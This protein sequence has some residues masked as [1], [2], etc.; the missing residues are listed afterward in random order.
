MKKYRY[1]FSNFSFWIVLIIQ[2][3]NENGGFCTDKIFKRL[4]R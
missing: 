2:H 1:S 3:E 4:F